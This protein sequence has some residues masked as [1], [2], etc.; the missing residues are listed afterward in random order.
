MVG[1]AKST[2]GDRST[3]DKVGSKLIQI[4]GGKRRA[5]WYN[6]VGR[7]SDGFLF[8]QGVHEGEGVLININVEG[9][10]G[11][12]KKRLGAQAHSREMMVIS[13]E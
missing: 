5:W 9:T 2:D 3:Q 7:T 10:G 4:V 13:P 8:D 12:E 11:E 1:D 6:T